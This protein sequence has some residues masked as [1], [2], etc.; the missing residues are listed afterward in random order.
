L[1]GEVLLF[2]NESKAEAR[3][4]RGQWKTHGELCQLLNITSRHD[5]HELSECLDIW[6]ELKWLE[7]QVS[8]WATEGKLPDNSKVS[9]PLIT[10][11]KSYS[12]DVYKLAQVKSL[13]EDDL[14][15]YVDETKKLIGKDGLE[16]IPTHAHF[17]KKGIVG[18][19]LRRLLR[20]AGVASI[21]RK[22]IHKYE[23][24]YRGESPI[25]SRTKRG[26]TPVWLRSL[27][28]AGPQLCAAINAKA[29]RK[30]ISP[31]ALYNA[32]H[33][34][35]CTGDRFCESN[36][37]NKGDGVWSFWRLPG[38]SAL[39]EEE[40]LR[41]IADFRQSSGR[42]KTAPSS[43]QAVNAAS[44]V[45]P[46]SNNPT[47]A[48]VETSLASTEKQADRFSELR[49]FAMKRLK[50]NGQRVVILAC[51]NDGSFPL[52]DLAVELRWQIPCDDA[53]NVTQ[54]RINT[55]LKAAKLPWIL[56][57]KS[58]KATLKF[59]ERK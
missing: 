50:G 57:R 18:K 27:L 44:D 47:A 37:L 42:K 25:Q 16:T 51:D 49:E 22:G 3:V 17:R 5:R 26:V 58:N 2:K 23:V 29:A 19:R 39:S 54:Q 24:K 12:A 43:P 41:L 4:N 45:N 7:K 9:R 35:N 21:R 34:L 28:A 46:A 40:S 56:Q 55:K 15:Q 11:V 38:Q 1:Q 33:E 8:R 6:V 14:K 59:L 30:R 32:F 31:S 10:A 36:G 53:Y 48:A 20:L 52:A 13:W